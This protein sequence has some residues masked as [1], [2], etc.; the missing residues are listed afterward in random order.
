MAKEKRDDIK[1]S[2]K[3]DVL[4]KKVSC[5]FR[6]PQSA[7]QKAD[8]EQLPMDRRN[9]LEASRRK[10]AGTMSTAR[11]TRETN[12]WP[13]VETHKSRLSRIKR[14]KDDKLVNEQNDLQRTLRNRAQILN[15]SQSLHRSALFNKDR[16][17]P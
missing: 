10:S 8:E 6:H 3:V 2:L 5:K 15:R 4:E 12:F 17:N 14:A 7:D 13:L 9:R 11:D 1:Q 16:L